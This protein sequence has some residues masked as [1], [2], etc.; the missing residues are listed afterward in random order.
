MTSISRRSLVRS[1][2]AAPVVAATVG[3][4]AV[5]AAPSSSRKPAP[6]ATLRIGRFEVMALTDG[7][8]DMP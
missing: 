2:A 5:I 6:I 3:S 1:L 4:G 8:A 7:F